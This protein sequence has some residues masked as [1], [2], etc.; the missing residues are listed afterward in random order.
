MMPKGRE[1]EA[2]DV[3]AEDIDIHAAET[4]HDVV[5]HMASADEEEVRASP[6]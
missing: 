1:A 5:K 4:L 2:P 3:I 6:H